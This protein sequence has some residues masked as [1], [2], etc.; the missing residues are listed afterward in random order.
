MVIKDIGWRNLG[1]DGT[2]TGLVVSNI[3]N[4]IA[5]GKAIQFEGSNDLIT[6]SG[7]DFVS[8]NNFS[9]SMWFKTT[10]TN[11]LTNL[12]STRTNT[13]SS[14]GYMFR[15]GNGTGTM[16]FFAYADGFKSTAISKDL[17]DG[18]W[19]HV[20]GTSDG[21]NI[22]LYCD[23]EFASSTPT[24]ADITPGSANLILGNSNDNTRDYIGLIDHTIIFDKALTNLEVT[25][26]FNA[27][28]SGK[29]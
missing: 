23:G 16:D 25:D 8:L 3:V 22:I 5:G 1:N 24:G 19:H 29:R 2:G 21:T 20:V 9:I 4:G 28:R 14:D 13:A 11:A 10:S 18:Q 26:L 6:I 12:M 7:T 15:F 17:R 27:Q